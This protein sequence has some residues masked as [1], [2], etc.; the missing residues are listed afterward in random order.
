MVHILSRVLLLC[1]NQQKKP[2]VAP[3][4]CQEQECSDKNW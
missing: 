3:H 1:L 4:D 2:T